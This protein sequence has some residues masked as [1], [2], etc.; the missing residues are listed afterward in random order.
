MVKKADHFMVVDVETSGLDPETASIVSIYLGICIYSN[1]RFEI[2]DEF[3][4]N[5]APDDGVYRISRD[6]VAFHDYKKI[7]ETSISYSDAA[8]MMEKF[9][10]NYMTNLGI[11]CKFVP[12]GHS[13]EF[14]LSFVYKHLMRRKILE[15]YVSHHS[16]DTHIIANTLFQFGLIRPESLTLESLAKYF[17]ID[18]SRLKLHGAKDDCAATLLVLEKLIDHLK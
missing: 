18:I 4:H 8:E 5:L 14:D 1:G 12:I 2:I 17:E 9:F 13:I 3:E 6:A 10:C 16:I 15:L 7:V 11:S